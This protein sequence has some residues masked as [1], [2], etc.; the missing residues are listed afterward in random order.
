DTEGWAALDALYAENGRWSELGDVL[1]RRAALTRD[2]PERAQLLARRAQVLLDWLKSPEEAAAALRH[3]RTIAPEDGSLADQLVA[4]LAKADRAREAAAI[5]EGR[6][7]HLTAPQPAELVGERTNP[8]PRG[9][10]AGLYI[11]LAQL[12]L[13]RLDDREGAREAIDHALAL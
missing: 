12:R 1:R 11:R 3:A 8:V 9:E 4:A 13:E 5:L 7:A 6:I 10:V 2:P